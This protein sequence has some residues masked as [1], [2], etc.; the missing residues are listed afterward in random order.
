MMYFYVNN[1]KTI[2]KW[3][4]NIKILSCSPFFKHIPTN[5]DWDGSTRIMMRIVNLIKML[6]FVHIRFE[7]DKSIAYILIIYK[8][9][10]RF[11]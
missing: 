5:K 2:E 6:K 4:S 3:S 11:Y 8:R 1:P 7:N 10:P 9:R